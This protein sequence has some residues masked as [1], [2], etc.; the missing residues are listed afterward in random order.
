MSRLRRWVQ[1]NHHQGPQ[2]R[3]ATPRGTNSIQPNW[4]RREERAK[5]LAFGIGCLVFRRILC[6]P[7][8][9]LLT[10]QT[11][12]CVKTDRLFLTLPGQDVISVRYIY[13]LECGK[14]FQI[15]D[16]CS[17]ICECMM[18]MQIS[19]VCSGSGVTCPMSAPITAGGLL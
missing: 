14:V 17:E 5:T 15:R 4:S 16:M 8:Y 3:L 11:P 2:W 18:D 9:N 13:D 10:L 12:S 7:F 1:W 19:S 6:F